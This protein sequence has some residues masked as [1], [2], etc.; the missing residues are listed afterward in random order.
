MS[1]REQFRIGRRRSAET[2]KE[3]LRLVL[4]HDRA[5]LS[6]RSLETLKDELIDV[7]SQHVEIDKKAVRISLTRDRERQRLVADI[8]LV[9]TRSRRGR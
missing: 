1:L 8:P 3:R 9:P 2:A 5:G 7:I 6:P 4:V